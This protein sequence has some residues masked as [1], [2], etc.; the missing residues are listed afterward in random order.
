[1]D[2]KYFE[3]YGLRYLIGTCE[4]VRAGAKR[5]ES[6]CNCWLTNFKAD[7]VEE[8]RRQLLGW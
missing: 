4:G 5:R 2:K 8:K 6:T 7:M 1:M 3:N